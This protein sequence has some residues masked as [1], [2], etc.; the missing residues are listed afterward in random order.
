MARVTLGTSRMQEIR[1]PGS[2]RAKPNGIATRPRSS[3]R[4]HRSSNGASTLPKM[5]AT[6]DA[7]TL[8]VSWA[9]H[10]QWRYQATTD[11]SPEP[12]ETRL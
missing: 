11:R 2:V 5:L 1:P 9:V 3:G 6:D 12:S 8:T 7:E 4:T 10:L